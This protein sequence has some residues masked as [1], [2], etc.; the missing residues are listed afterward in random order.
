MSTKT[1]T[2]TMDASAEDRR[3]VQGIK[4]DDEGGSRSTTV[5]AD[6]QQ[7]RSV[8]FHFLRVANSNTVSS[9]SSLCLA[10]IF[11]SSDSLFFV[12][13]MKY[14]QYCNHAENIFVPNVH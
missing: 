5:L 11:F 1:T 3:R 10:L 4:Y 6:G 8:D 7:Q 2:M 12:H 9:L 13:Y 14:Y